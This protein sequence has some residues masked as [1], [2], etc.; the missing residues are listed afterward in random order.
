MARREQQES[1]GIERQYIEAVQPTQF[2]I[3]RVITNAIEVALRIL[4]HA[5]P[6][7]VR[8]C[9]RV[10]RRRVRVLFRFGKLVVVAMF[11]RPPEWT[12]LPRLKPDQ[13]NRDLNKAA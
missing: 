10:R 9:E 3:S 2:G 8:A 12:S 6:G 13:G 7:Q 5:E 11:A 4:R 1:P